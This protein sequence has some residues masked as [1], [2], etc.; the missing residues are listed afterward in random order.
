MSA[1]YVLQDTGDERLIKIGVASNPEK[2]AKAQC[3][4]TE[5]PAILI[6]YVDCGIAGRAIEQRAHLILQHLRVFDEWFMC[7][8]DE[9]WGAIRMARTFAIPISYLKNPALSIS[10]KLG[11]ARKRNGIGLEAWASDRKKA[12]SQRLRKVAIIRKR[13]VTSKGS[14][15]KC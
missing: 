14:T 8:S 12:I 6:G 5:K 9:A 4:L 3:G 7:T 11:R 2:R 13:E 15:K 10:L 1:V